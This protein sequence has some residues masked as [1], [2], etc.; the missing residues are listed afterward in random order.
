MN[1]FD[2]QA[3]QLIS[4]VTNNPTPLKMG[5]QGSPPQGAI[6]SNSNV[7]MCEHEINVHTGACNHDSSIIGFKDK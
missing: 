3:H 4:S 2:P 7:Y 6:T 1:H 5:N